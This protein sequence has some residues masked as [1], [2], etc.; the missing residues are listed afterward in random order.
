MTG[1]LLFWVVAAAVAAMAAQFKDRS[2]GLW[3]AYGLL[4]GPLAVLQIWRKPSVPEP[5]PM[6]KVMPA[7]IP[8]SERGQPS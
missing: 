5:E 3:F 8:S 6:P 2:P 4:L 7:T 1:F